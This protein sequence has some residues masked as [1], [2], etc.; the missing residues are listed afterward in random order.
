MKEVSELVEA[1]QSGD[2]EA[3]DA[4]MQ[5]FQ[6]MANAIAS[7]KR[8]KLG[9]RH[10]GTID[11]E[12][13]KAPSP[14][15]LGA[16]PRVIAD[17]AEHPRC[18]QVE[19]VRREAGQPFDRSRPLRVVGEAPQ[20]G[21]GPAAVAEPVIADDE[22]DRVAQAQCG[23]DEAERHRPHVPEGHDIRPVLGQHAL[24]LC[25]IG[26]LNLQRLSKRRIEAVP[27]VPVAA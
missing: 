13:G 21:I 8:G 22:H 15:L 5:R 25:L 14:D 23:R 9:R 26:L 20:P 1:A 12:V 24:E 27:P 10:A 19:K 17:K 3:Y 7:S 6:Q 16:L 18:S 2:G 4:L 11:V